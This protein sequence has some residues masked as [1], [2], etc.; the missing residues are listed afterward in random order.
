MPRLPAD[1]IFSV[2]S[3]LDRHGIYGA[4]PGSGSSQQMVQW[5]WRDDRS[6]WHSY[7]SLDSRIIEVQHLSIQILSK[8]VFIDFNL[9]KK[10]IIISYN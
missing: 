9:K 10:I 6:M 3:L 8:F 7:T 4:V 1:G 2:D 5:Q